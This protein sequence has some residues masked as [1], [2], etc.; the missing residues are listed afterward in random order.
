MIRRR[1][2]GGEERREGEEQG[3]EEEE[4]ERGGGWRE[5]GEAEAN[6]VWTTP[7]P[8][9]VSLSLSLLYLLYS[10]LLSRRLSPQLPVIYFT[11]LFIH[12]TVLCSALY[13]YFS[14]SVD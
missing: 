1:S 3:R 9:A 10:T 5:K 2:K 6:R 7:W 13:L 14:F 12:S 11:L 8:T 4:R